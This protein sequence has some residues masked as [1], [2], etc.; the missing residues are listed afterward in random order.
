MLRLYQ[1][2]LLGKPP[3]FPREIETGIDKYLAE[4]AELKE[5]RRLEELA[6]AEAESL[7]WI[8]FTR[9]AILPFP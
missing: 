2:D 8:S 7:E 1:N 9:T 3:R 6:L 4:Q 5:S